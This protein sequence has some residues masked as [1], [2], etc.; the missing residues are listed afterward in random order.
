MDSKNG[1][2]RSIGRAAIGN[3][4]KCICLTRVL[5]NYIMCIYIWAI[6]LICFSMKSIR[7]DKNAK[8]RSIFSEEIQNV[9]AV[10]VVAI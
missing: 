9:I 2:M 1:W 4:L 6:F 8:F 10:V 5:S 3:F 7:Y